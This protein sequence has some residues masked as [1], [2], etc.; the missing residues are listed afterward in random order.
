[1]SENPKKVPEKP[2]KGVR[3][4]EEGAEEPEKGV[5]NPKKV[6]RSLKKM[7]E[8]VSEKRCYKKYR[9]RLKRNTV[10]STIGNLNNVAK[11]I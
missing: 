6:L 4:P 10:M 8:K 1:M 3:K 11:V 5:R 9:M 7:P 2:E